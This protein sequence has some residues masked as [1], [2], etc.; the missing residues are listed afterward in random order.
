MLWLD[1]SLAKGVLTYLA[2]RQATEV[3][4]FKDSQPGKIMHETR[5]GE[6]SAL[7]EVPFGLYCGQTSSPR[8]SGCA[9][10]ATATAMV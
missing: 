9:T 8:P 6:M 7:G 4:A 10:G 3:D 5:G 2:S 1:P